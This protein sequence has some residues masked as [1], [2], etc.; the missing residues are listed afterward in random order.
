MT[1]TPKVTATEIKKIV[2]QVQSNFDPN[3]TTRLGHVKFSKF[4][5]NGVPFAWKEGKELTVEMAGAKMP[6]SKI[7]KAELQRVLENLDFISKLSTAFP[8]LEV[9]SKV[10]KNTVSFD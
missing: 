7:D 10:D 5:K 9:K 4:I 6:V 3:N 2:T 1:D 8:K